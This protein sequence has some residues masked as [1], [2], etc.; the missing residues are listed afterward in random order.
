MEREQPENRV[1]VE[2]RTFGWWHFYWIFALEP[3]ADCKLQAFESFW[4]SNGDAETS[5][6]WFMVFSINCPSETFGV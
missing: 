2:L 5:S 4:T 6:C 3:P 1:I